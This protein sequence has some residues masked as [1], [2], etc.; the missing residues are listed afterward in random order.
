MKKISEKKQG[1]ELKISRLYQMAKGQNPDSENKEKYSLEEKYDAIHSELNGCKKKERD[2]LHVELSARLESAKQ[3]KNFINIVSL[4]VSFVA[5]LISI[6]M[7]ILEKMI[8]REELPTEQIFSSFSG[9][10]VTMGGIGAL[11]ILVYYAMS[12]Y[13]DRK[14]RQTGYLLEILK[15]VTPQ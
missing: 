14:I 11:M 1:L 5:I 6:A 12:E 10:L 7:P 15:N 8:D 4:A 9:L 3:V 2:I 13:S